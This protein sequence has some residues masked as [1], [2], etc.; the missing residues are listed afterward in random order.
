MKSSNNKSRGES[1]PNGT[2]WRLVI[3]FLIFTIITTTLDL[4]LNW[5]KHR[6]TARNLSPYLNKEQ[7]DRI[8]GTSLEKSIR[9][10][11][12]KKLKSEIELET[13]K[14][15]DKILNETPPHPPSFIFE[16]PQGIL[17]DITDISN[18]LPLRT[19]IVYGDGDTALKEINSIDSYT[20]TFQLK[21]RIPRAATNLT[22]IEDG[23]PGLRKILPGFNSLFPLGFVSP[24]HQKIYQNKVSQIRKHSK[25]LTTI[26]A[27]HD[28]YDCN[29]I[30]HLRSEKGRKVF[31]MQAD[32]DA[33]L[34]GADGDRLSEIPLAQVN[35][36]SYDP[37][38]AYHWRKTGTRPNPMIAG[39]ERRIAIGGK[40]LEIP[41]LTPERKS[42]VQERIVM[43]QNGINAMKQ[44]S[45]LISSY[46]PY[47]S[48]PL[49]ILKDVKDPYAPKIGD[50]AVVIH[51]NKIY[52]CI[53]GDAGSDTA[54]GE[55]SARLAQ[56][57]NAGWKN[58]KK[59]IEAPIVSYLVFPE[60]RDADTSVPDYL[61][62]EK[63]CL[64]LLNE[65]GGI[66][67]SYELHRWKHGF[68]PIAS[69]QSE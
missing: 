58:G 49:S 5:S 6:E 54:L 11:Y 3:L 17:S 23:T 57:L 61:K 16:K 59:A 19:E 52:P 1:F 32:L 39:W 42:W 45:Y 10:E 53:V 29:T 21:L 41:T 44:R 4:I 15:K 62:W 46:D 43:L 66:G 47:I 64:A 60:S 20:A 50:Y 35:S 56:Q 36:I 9:E 31:Y 38:T 37:F 13:V 27:K 28:A 25:Q 2:G 26:L 22:E 51:D 65:I 8:H 34:K 40:E 55:A 68:P 30:L 14:I 18:G 69:P 63:K 67:K 33:T 48:L 12:E 7:E 24:W